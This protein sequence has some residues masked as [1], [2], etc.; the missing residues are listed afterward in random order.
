[1]NQNNNKSKLLLFRLF[2]AMPLFVLVGIGGYFMFSNETIRLNEFVLL[3]EDLPPIRLVEN[4]ASTEGL[5]MFPTHHPLG[6][7]GGYGLHATTIETGYLHFFDDDGHLAFN[8]H[9][10]LQSIEDSIYIVFSNFLPNLLPNEVPPTPRE[11]FILKVFYEFEEVAFYVSDQET[12][13]TEFLFH[14]AEGYQVQLPIQLSQ[15]VEVNNGWGNL[16]IAIFANPHYNTV[17]PLAQWYSYCAECVVAHS[18][19][20][21]DI[22]I[23]SHFSLS[24][25]ENSEP[26]FGEQVGA[27][28]THAAL[29]IS[30]EFSEGQFTAFP[31]SPWT[32]TTGEEVKIGFSFHNMID[33][34]SQA[35][36]IEIDDFVIIGLLNWEQVALNEHA[37]YFN[38]FESMPNWGSENEMTEGYFTIIAPNEPGY[39]D[40]VAFAIANV[41]A[42]YQFQQG[43]IAI[44]FTLR[45]N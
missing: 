13:T 39:Y 12:L 33:P 41:D 21:H 7:G 16:T 35:E 28:E 27:L 44:R 26:S 2:L 6:S 23:A 20:T 8:N 3:G 22:G 18:L 14:L 40:F 42:P 45:V 1:M 38:Y 37:Y 36:V 15:A 5:N 31:P 34:P 25:G 30:P 9:L 4:N 19:V 17:N 29:L 10:T 24:F 43:A 11:Q 32:V